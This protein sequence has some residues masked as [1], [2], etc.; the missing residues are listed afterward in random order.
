MQYLSSLYL[1]GALAM[2]CALL[3]SV[4][5]LWGYSLVLRGDEGALR[6]A[7]RAYTCFAF[8]VV[9][10][11]VVMGF[12]LVTRDFRIEYVH[13]Y[14]GLD[15]PSHYQLAAFWAGQKG[16]FLI[17]LLW[18]SLLG[19]GVY[20]TAGKQEPTVMAI[21]L[22]TLL[23]LVFILVRENPFVM[24]NTTPTDG[25]GLNPLLQDNWM[26][27]HPP[28][29]F[30][31]FAASAIPFSFAMASLWRRDTSGNWARRAFPWAL[32]GF[33][34]LGLAILLGGYWAYTTL[35]WGGYWGWDP[36]ENASFIPFLFGTVLIHGLYMERS[37]GR[38]R[39][40]NYVLATLVFMSVL[41]GTFLTRSGVLADFSVHSFV[42][43][44]IS[45]WLIG[46]M[47]FFLLLSIYLLASRLPKMPTHP[48]EDP[49]VSRGTVLVLSSIVILASA[50]MITAGT[51]A[52]LLTAFLKNPGQV[53]PEFYN[54]VNLPIAL[55]L[56]LLL[57]VVPFLTWKGTPLRELGKK[58]LPSAI[59]AAAVA[60]FA[61][62]LAVHNP[63]HLAYVFLATLALGTN[64]HK[65]VLKGR[66]RGLAS[67]GGY[68]AH[69]GVGIILLGFIA[70]SAYDQ[71]TKVTLALDQPQKVGENTLTFIGFAKKKSPRDKDAMVVQVDTP[72]GG[73][74][75][76]YPKM[77]R[78]NRTGQ[79][80]VNPDV[81]NTLLQDYYVSPLAYSIG[82]RADEPEMVELVQ[83]D[84]TEVGKYTV[85]FNGLD[86][87]IDGNAL[88]KM[89]SGEGVVTIGAKLDMIDPEGKTT[90][91][92]P[93]FK[94]DQARRSSDTPPL[95]MDTG[96][97]VRI[98]GIDPKNGKVQLAFVGVPGMSAEPTTLSIDVS[99]KPL[100]QLVWF[101]LY[102]ILFGGILSMVKRVRQSVRPDPIQ[103]EAPAGAGAGDKS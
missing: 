53:G 90:P 68:L 85:R 55:L 57:A 60:T 45:G 18:G 51:S 38:F 86:L 63:F 12:A 43:L 30:I 7:R 97:M 67:A 31:G 2:W 20:R 78:N 98:S 73:R 35:G 33:M 82:R 84:S 87:G 19:L 13:Q 17:W 69:V 76:S 50:V 99:R 88:A 89:Q 71:S 15:L 34:V 72:D 41:Y 52:P 64:L 40:I 66:D 74:F 102:V 25:Q 65:T 48:N 70:S 95:S 37:K 44:G 46:L 56:A 5:A 42:D 75:Y 27:I 91:V 96:G 29:M 61:G 77:F 1:P 28:I 92:L 94:V 14:S 81:K 21:Y 80:M 59:V 32:G 49:L 9:L 39:R 100:I 8:S 62:I 24:L 93:L 83:G 54:Q 101:G 6:F 79:T 11:A 22:T 47:A 103:Q 58:I 3:F 23:G 16:S 10:A 4:T 26:V 36:V